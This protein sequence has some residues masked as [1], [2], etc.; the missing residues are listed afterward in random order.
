MGGFSPDLQASEIQGQI[1]GLSLASALPAG[2]QGAVFRGVHAEHGDVV[3][4]VVL[5]QFEE[6]TR[7]EIDALRTL[8]LPNVVRLLDH[9]Y[10]DVRQETCPYTLTRLVTGDDIRTRILNGDHMDEFQA[11]ELIRG[12]AAA[13]DELWRKEI[14]HR[15]VKPPNIIWSTLGTAVLIDLGVARHLTR[16]DLTTYGGWLGTRGFMAPEQASGEKHLTVRA[17]VFGLGV[18]AH[19]AI[20]GVH[21][22]GGQDEIMAGKRPTSVAT[23]SDNLSALLLSMMS[24]RPIDRPTARNLLEALS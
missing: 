2:G 15:D 4:K 24:L 17:D 3:L 18:T 9:G 22:F 14:V 12:V 8:R 23:V 5:P 13:L 10:I 1:P 21:P 16:T 19:M 6:R 11:R 20:T 7:R